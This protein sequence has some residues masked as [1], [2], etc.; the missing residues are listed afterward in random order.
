[1]LQ[2]ASSG[3][4]TDIPSRK[5]SATLNTSI[6]TDVPVMP[7][8]RQESA[9]AR[10]IKRVTGP[11][12]REG[13]LTKY[14]TM[15]DDGTV[16]GDQPSEEAQ[17]VPPMRREWKKAPHNRLQTER[18]KAEWFR[19]MQH[20]MMTD[21]WTPE[22]GTGA[23]TT[24][25]SDIDVKIPAFARPEHLRKAA[26]AKSAEADA[27]NRAMAERAA[28]EAAA[29]AGGEAPP[30]P[31]EGAEGEPLPPASEPE[32]FS[33]DPEIDVDLPPFLDWD[34]RMKHFIK[35]VRHYD[36]DII[37]LN[38][39]NKTHFATTMWP[40]IRYEGYGGLYV[41]SR[42]RKVKALKSIDDAS[43]PRHAGKATHHED[44]GNAIFFH[45][46]RFVPMMLPGPETPRHLHF[47][48][49][50]SLRDTI[51][52][53]EV[54]VANLQLT[55][56]ATKEAMQLREYEVKA[57]LTVIDAIVS[58]NSSRSHGTIIVCG[59]L[60]NVTDDEPCVE[61][62]R[63]RFYST[64]DVAGGPRWT[65]WYHQK[66]DTPNKYYEGNLGMKKVVDGS[67][68][69][70][71]L[72]TAT[73]M[74]THMKSMV[75][76]PAKAKRIAEIEAAAAAKKKAAED[77]LRAPVVPLD[78]SEAGTDAL[79]L[80]KVLELQ[81]GVVHRTQDFVF[82]D[83]SRIGLLQV[84]DVPSDDQVDQNTLLPNRKNPSHHVPLVVD[85]AFHD[86]NPDV[87]LDSLK[88]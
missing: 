71:Q 53:L 62:L 29:E 86:I 49:F 55:A 59:D 46:S 7:E 21:Q 25:V 48:I 14:T 82:Y 13:G 65:A 44:I 57:A 52:N 27:Y 4:T 16:F 80:S 54:F 45:R 43:K 22:R 41:S 87:L 1:M 9:L 47:G 74:P 78:V 83:P 36:P 5:Q 15:R 76:G 77:A 18:T 24:P 38:E 39:L 12:E 61:I 33:Y 17:Y 50:A 67:L 8:K 60:N 84:L 58:N 88:P 42:G 75:M 56:G 35:E 26:S 10:L 66:S 40:H 85:L 30:P 64:Y 79:V 68:K 31:A 73:T 23:L 28:A 37:C 19:F 72:T 34:F 51:T 63:D 81:K 2:G 20:N 69:Q 11:G 3:M 6:R 32:V 70:E